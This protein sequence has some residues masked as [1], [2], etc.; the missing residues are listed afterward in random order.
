[1]RGASAPRGH[2][3][4]ITELGGPLQTRTLTP[5]PT[6]P[7]TV[8]V[9]ESDP[10]RRALRA[11]AS[12]ILD[13]EGFAGLSLRR[14]AK[15]AGVTTMGI[16]SRFGGKDGLLDALCL[17]GF[18]RL[19]AAQRA[20]PQTV[21]PGG[22]LRAHARVQHDVAM[23]H[24]AHYQVMFGRPGGF[25]RSE[26]SEQ[27]AART[28]ASLRDAVSRCLAAGALNGDADE[29]AD[30]IFALVHGHAS[31]DAAGHPRASSEARLDAALRAL[32][33]GYALS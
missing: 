8:D 6:T 17:E 31:A 16:Y 5:R 11:A 9:P 12:R 18:E 2:G 20:L 7:I 3:T 33:R 27:L 13:A 15:E 30:A 21:A 14:V 10:T 32:L 25:R 29:I 4:D 19:Q 26:A 22:D 23:A 28:F 1:M 24:P